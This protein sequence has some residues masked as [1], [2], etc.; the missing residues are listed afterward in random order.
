MIPNTLKDV[1]QVINNWPPQQW[2]VSLKYAHG[3]NIDAI[4]YQNILRMSDSRRHSTGKGISLPYILT[5][6]DQL[7][8]LY[9]ASPGGDTHTDIGRMTIQSHVTMEITVE[10]RRDPSDQ[11]FYIEFFKDGISLGRMLNENPTTYE[12]VYVIVGNASGDNNVV[13]NIKFGEL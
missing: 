3:G 9:S 4:K 1:I 12:K 6:S 11:K 8:A 2:Y 5:R 13:S 7:R 10:Q